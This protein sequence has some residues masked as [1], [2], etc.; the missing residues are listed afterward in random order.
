MLG[1][2]QVECPQS[3]LRAARSSAPL[4]TAIVNAG[5]AVVMESA[6]DAASA[7][8]IEPVFFGDS[9]AIQ[10]YASELNWDISGYEVIES[11]DEQSAAIA[12]A[13]AASGGDVAAVMKGHIHTDVFMR[14][15]LSRNANLRTERRLTHVFHMTVPGRE[16]QLLLT[17]CAVNI[18]PDVETKKAV[19]QNAVDLAHA[20]GIEKPKV[21]LLSAT[22]EQ[23]E[24]MPSSIEAKLLTDWARDSVKSADVF[25][26]LAMDLA[27]SADAART[28][29]VDHPVAGHADIIV[30][31]DIVTGN[32][33]FKMMVHYM[34]ACAAGIGLGAKVPILLTS[35][36]DPPAARL[37]SA[38][39]AAIVKNHG[40]QSA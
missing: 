5:A 15:L 8:V 20:L 6:Y 30:V 3:L 23:M 38:A 2:N 18:H 36:A 29:G 26:P 35:R 12:A 16:G 25:G 14:A 28:K 32:A 19:I 11:G 21:A 37:A 4:R 9:D 10:K 22:E 13:S 27:L 7:G 31:P 34:N 17:D 1:K 33:L 24:Q 40:D 39:L